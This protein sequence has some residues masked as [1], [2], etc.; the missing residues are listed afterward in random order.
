MELIQ[1]VFFMDIEE[2]NNKLFCKPCVIVLQGAL[3]NTL[4]LFLAKCL[5]FFKNIMNNYFF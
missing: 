4:K 1:T 3:L 2:K 5:I